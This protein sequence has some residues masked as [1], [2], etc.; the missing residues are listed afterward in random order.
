ML[1][2]GLNI[3]NAT[4]GATSPPGFSLNKG[5]AF[6][7]TK[8]LATDGINDT[9]TFLD[10]SSSPLKVIDGGR[11]TLAFWFKV[12]L[13]SDVYLY[14]RGNSTTYFRLF[15]STSTD[16]FAIIGLNTT[17]SVF[18]NFNTASNFLTADTW[19]HLALTLE[20]SSLWSAVLYIDGTAITPSSAI[21]GGASIAPGTSAD[22]IGLSI[23]G[24]YSSVRVDELACWDS[25]LTS[26]EIAELQSH[27]NL[28]QDE[29]DYTS[30]ASLERWYRME[31]TAADETGNG[32]DLRLINGPKYVGDKPF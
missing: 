2:L 3:K 21:Y 27:Y 15:Y 10:D 9:I 19:Q 7:N 25:I 26:S 24:A 11:G 13:S 14:N 17:F 29:G 22:K 31:S 6:T 28:S 30:S 12:S 18:L 8:G 4:T 16:Q 5:L 1:G 23:G 20:R 32:G